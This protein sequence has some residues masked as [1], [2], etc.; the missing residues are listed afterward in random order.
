MRKSRL[1]FTGEGILHL[2][3]IFLETFVLQNSI[4]KKG[5]E[6]KHLTKSEEILLVA[7]WKLGDNAYGVPIKDH[8][9]E[10][11]GRIMSFGALYV[12]LDKLAKK[13][14]VTKTKGDPTPERGGR[15]KIFYRLTTD[16]MKAL[17]A[18]RELNE[19]LWKNVPKFFFK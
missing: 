5:E 9:S 8:V 10:V 3:L 17:Q 6:M 11:T 7:I 18:A 13:G 1:I 2:R 4:Y 15:H 12:S 14:Y 19:L 16:G